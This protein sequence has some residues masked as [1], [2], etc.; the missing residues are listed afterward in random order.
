VTHK[1]EGL[2]AT[3]RTRLILNLV[4]WSAQIISVNPKQ[5]TP[6]AFY[7][8]IFSFLSSLRRKHLYLAKH[9]MCVLYIMRWSEP[10][11]QT[12]I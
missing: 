1:A 9:L 10:S 4:R 5:K 8:A 11:L 6:Q 2:Y 12:V 7:A 3:N